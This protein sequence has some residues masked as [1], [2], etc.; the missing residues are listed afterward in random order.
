MRKSGLHASPSGLIAIAVLT[1]IFGL[2]AIFAR[3]LS[4]ETKLFEQWYLRYGIMSVLSVIVFHRQVD[5]NKFLHLK[6]KEWSVILFRSFIGSVLAVSLYTVAAREAK[7]GIVAFMQVVP[8]TALLGILL[9]HERVSKA[10]A[11][12]IL[13]AFLGAS[14]VVVENFHDLANV[15][16]GAVWSLVSGAL[17]ALQ[18]V[19]RKWHSKALNNQELTVAIIVSGFVMNYLLSLILYHRFFVSTEN[20]SPQFVLVLLLAGCCGVAN[21][22]LINY[23]FE[24]VSAVIASNV[25]SLE[26]VFGALFGFLIYDEVLGMRVIIGGLIILGSVIATNYLNNREGVSEQAEPVP[27]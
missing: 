1:L 19:T 25:L 2:T 18:L 6:R 17:F 24:H 14:L 11:A 27:D 9:F 5:F 21:I 12:T 10:R 3:Y 22:F 26:A 8:C 4:T 13:L 20:W 16:M 7:I 15:N 23:G